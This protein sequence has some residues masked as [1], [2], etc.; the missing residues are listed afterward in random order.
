MNKKKTTKEE[1]VATEGHD[2]VENTTKVE[3]EGVP[4]EASE[5]EFSPAP[6]EDKECYVL[7]GYKLPVGD[8]TLLDLDLENQDLGN[9]LVLLNENATYVGLRL[10][11]VSFRE[12]LESHFAYVE[13]FMGRKIESILRQRQEPAIHIFQA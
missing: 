7:I 9:C 3:T 6:T 8:D 10:E 1:T 11:A 5:D 4:T 13:V 2:I 12:T